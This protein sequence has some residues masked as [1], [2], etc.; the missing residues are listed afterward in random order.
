[1]NTVI[2]ILLVILAVGST[3]GA[4]LDL[5]SNKLRTARIGWITSPIAANV[6]AIPL[7]ALAFL[8]V[9]P[10]DRNTRD[11]LTLVAFAPGGASSPLLARTAGG[12]PTRIALHYTILAVVSAPLVGLVWPVFAVEQSL[13]PTLLVGVVA[14][15]LVPLGFGFGLRVTRPV[16][17]VRIAPHVR[18]FGNG[19]LLATIV[20][21]AGARGGMLATL[22]PATI[23]G[24]ASGVVA[25][26]AIGALLAG[27]QRAA[28]GTLACVRNLTLVLMVAEAQDPSGRGTVVI[29]AYGLVMYL[30]ATALALAARR[31]IRRGGA[32]G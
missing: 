3:F 8:A 13:A 2:A 23:A 4:G 18:S 24:I 26:L 29:A 21:L 27:S 6:V 32:T 1:M 17:A 5:D 10:V 14:L 15:Q 30:A 16:A 25:T 7:V 19:L 11:V 12:D 9:L 31:A 28:A 20:A 22:D